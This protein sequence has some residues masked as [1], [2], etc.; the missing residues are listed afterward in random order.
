MSAARKIRMT[1]AGTATTER[2]MGGKLTPQTAE[3]AVDKCNHLH[4]SP[5]YCY[6]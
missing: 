4:Y 5:H 3:T 6:F 1:A 2:K